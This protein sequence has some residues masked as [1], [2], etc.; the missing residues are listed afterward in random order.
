MVSTPSAPDPRETATTQ[1]SMNRDTAIT[2]QLLNMINQ[3]TPDGSLTYTQTGNTFTP[4]KTGDTYWF[5]KKTG[6]YSSTD[7]FA[8]TRTTTTVDT[9]KTTANNWRTGVNS[10]AGT[11]GGMGKPPTY[12]KDGK[13]IASGAD[14]W[15]QVQGLLTPGYTA[16]TELSPENQKI[17]DEMMKSKYNLSKTASE[18]TEF[19]RQYL[20]KP[21]DYS[22]APEQWK[23]LGKNYNSDLGPDYATNVG[24]GYATS[25]AGADDFSAD[26]QR[27]EDAIMARQQPAMQQNRDRVRQQLIASG[28][29]PGTA[30]WDS[31]QARLSAAETDTRMA[32][33]LGAGD[34][35]ARMV[36]MA[37]DAAAFG[38][39]SLLARMQAQNAASMGKKGFENSVIMDKANFQNASRSQWLNEAYAK[40]NQPLQEISALL[41]GSQINNPNFVST[42][43]AQVGGVDY[44]G[45]VSDKYKADVSSSNAMMGGLFGLLSAPFQLSDIRAKEDIRRVGTT[46]A[47]A[48]VYVYRYK[49]DDVPRMGVMAQEIMDDQPEAVGIHPSGFLMVDY[50]KVH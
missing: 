22:G 9:T 37:R 47:G 38:N 31:E 42:P 18:Q 1:S 40:R 15:S 3:R 49:G 45:L 4:S 8:S 39:E 36:G 30:A 44:A 17:Y 24:D 33:I 21:M 5:N 25:Y 29:R 2:Q 28:L 32:A 23:Y 34:E 50:S 13:V 19:L 35:Q 26:R 16:T 43:T 6:E 46:D 11:G 27:Y 14:D 41:S 12:G 20:G 7:P 10:P 48:G